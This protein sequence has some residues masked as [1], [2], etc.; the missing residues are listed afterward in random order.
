VEVEEVAALCHG[1]H[2]DKIGLFLGLH[3]VQDRPLRDQVLT[4]VNKKQKVEIF[5]E[6]RILEILRTETQIIDFQIP[7]QISGKKKLPISKQRIKLV[8]ATI[9]SV[10]TQE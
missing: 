8:V 2:Q 1:L 10:I 3:Q 9:G 6:I 7:I 4:E 5:Q